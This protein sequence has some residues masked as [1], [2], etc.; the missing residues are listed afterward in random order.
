MQIRNFTRREILRLGLVSGLVGITGCTNSSN[1]LILLSP[2]DILPSRLKRTLPPDWRLKKL[3]IDSDKFIFSESDL[4]NANLIVVNDGWIQTISGDLLSPLSNES[5]SR[6]YD[7]QAL[8]FVR[9]LG[10]EY[11]DKVIPISVSP[12]VMLF[13]NGDQWIQSARQ[14]W[15]ILLDSSLKDLIVLPNSPRFIISIA[16]KIDDKLALRKLRKQ[17]GFFNYNSKSKTTLPCGRKLKFN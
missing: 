15:D 9:G 14:N 1:K 3:N 5:I 2:P 13:R 10:E 6:N 7:L 4:K 17:C 12:W 11:I 8:S 16:N